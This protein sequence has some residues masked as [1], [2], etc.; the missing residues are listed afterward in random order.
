MIPSSHWMQ[1][2]GDAG[3]GSAVGGAVLIWGHRGA[4]AIAASAAC[5]PQHRQRRS[6]EPGW[7]VRQALR[8]HGPGLDPTGAVAA[9]VAAAGVLL[10]PLRAA[11]DGAARL[12]PALSLVRRSRGR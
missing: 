11:A 6:G 5:D 3:L 8:R 2:G 10:D 1:G 7:G 4:G 9:V 12:Q